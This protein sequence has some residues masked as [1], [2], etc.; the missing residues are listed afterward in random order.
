[1]GAVEDM[2]GIGPVAG[3]QVTGGGGWPVAPIP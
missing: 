3:K 2:A 1:M